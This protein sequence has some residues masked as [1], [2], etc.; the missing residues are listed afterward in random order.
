[1]TLD[2]ADDATDDNDDEPQI[3]LLYKFR[4]LYI[5]MNYYYIVAIK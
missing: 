1:M 4:S 5:N 2:D 3:D